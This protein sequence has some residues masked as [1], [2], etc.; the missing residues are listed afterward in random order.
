MRDRPARARP[1]T[2]GDLLPQT[3]SPT[4]A[5]GMAEPRK[6][7]GAR[8]FARLWRRMPLD[9]LGFGSPEDENAANLRQWAAERFW[10][11]APWWSRR[12]LRSLS[13]AAWGV[14]ATGRTVR[15]SRVNSLS[16]PAT[17]QLLGDCLRSGA[18]PNEAHIWRHFFQPPGFH[19][20]AGR[21]AGA[22]LSRLGTRK[23]HLLLADKLAAARLLRQAR[24]PV[25]EEKL[26]IPEGGCVDPSASVW[27][28]AGKLFVK[29]RHGS[30]SRGS[31][32]IDVIR[33]GSYRMNGGPS[34]DTAVLQGR[35]TALAKT[36]TL[37]VQSRLEA[38]EETA[39]LASGGDA[40]VLR[41]TTAREPGGEPFL[42]SGLL[43]IRV[44]GENARHF[45]RG[46]IF[47]PVDPESGQMKPGI[48]FLRPGERF[49]RLPW[50]RVAIEG[51]FLPGYASAVSMAIRAMTLVPGL[52][53]VNWDLIL[54]SEGPV[55]LEGNTC[56]DWILT[57]L[58]A[59]DRGMTCPLFPL[60]WRW[61][62]NSALLEKG[63]NRRE[64]TA[65]R[66]G[67]TP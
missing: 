37:L 51:R 13:L 60:L 7:E 15:F 29:P 10:L 39:D 28:D 3:K 4:P 43:A 50:N 58:S 30:A 14:A 20:F 8:T 54:S 36:D 63:R 34:C 21:S 18:Q 25:P 47:A 44:P 46:Q 52:A 5:E 1:H 32:P 19:P 11:R 65:V 55:I 17:R 64:N 6:T 42:H 53:L 9:G 26:T 57:N 56:G 33:R 31:M 2:P 61:A 24:L 62:E 41:L 49:S 35:L 12:V 23:E 38:G 16:L 66:L 40:P 45:I 48:W 67:E 27:C 22:V 59:A